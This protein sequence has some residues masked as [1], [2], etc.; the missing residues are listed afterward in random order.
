M[1]QNLNKQS[2][3]GFG[4]ILRD[5]L[6]NRGFPKGDAWVEKVHYFSSGE[7]FFYSASAEVYLDFEIGMTVLAL[8]SRGKTVCFYLDKPVC[9]APETEFAIVPYQDECSVRVSLPKDGRLE[10]TAP[11]EVRENLKIGDRLHLGEIYTLF[12]R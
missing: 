8:R 1:I 12:Y 11:F 6:P 2:F 10:T 4:K 9:L 7:L 5:S 3:A